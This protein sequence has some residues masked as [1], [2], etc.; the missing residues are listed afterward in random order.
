MVQASTVRTIT[1]L[2]GE[3]NILVGTLEVTNTA[4]IIINITDTLHLAYAV[5]EKQLYVCD[6]YNY[7]FLGVFEIEGMCNFALAFDISYGGNVS[8]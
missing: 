1:R 7:V 5:E 2:L 3:K 6:Y 4:G 8:C